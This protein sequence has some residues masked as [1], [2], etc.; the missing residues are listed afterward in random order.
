MNKTHEIH[1]SLLK[2]H[3]DI[4]QVADLYP[5]N[6]I[7]PHDLLDVLASPNDHS[8]GFIYKNDHISSGHGETYLITDNVIDFRS[9][10][11][12]ESTSTQN[13][14][15]K[16]NGFLNYHR[17]LGIYTLIN[18]VPIINYIGTKSGLAYLK[19]V[20]IVDVGGGTGH[21]LASLYRFPQ[22]IRY[23]NID[24]NLRLLHD[25]FLRVYPELLETPMG[26]LLGFAEKLPFKK[27]S[28]DVVTSIE[29][30]DHMKNY[31]QFIN[32]AYTILKPGGILLI[33]GHLDINIPQEIK[34]EMPLIRFLE[35]MTRYAY[36]KIAY[37]NKTDDH[38]FHFSTTLEIEKNL[39]LNSF[40]IESS[41]VY[42]DNFFIKAIK[43]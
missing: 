9:A 26:H 42:L 30:I 34:N 13:W 11:K 22:T 40:R 33:A 28:I 10:G 7:I 38:T 25:Q 20:T 15:K 36:Y 35:R 6:R 17:S 29:S 4:Y 3:R 32:E 43:E 24:P 41:Q 23:I 21:S 39:R 5:Q 18:S 19:N 2:K 14:D 37:K 16:N 12:M 1:L 31:Q 8:S 27:C